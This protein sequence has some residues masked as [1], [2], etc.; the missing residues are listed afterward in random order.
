[1][2]SGQLDGSSWMV[3]NCSK[4]YGA[5]LLDHA[6][7]AVAAWLIRVRFVG[8]SRLDCS[9]LLLVFLASGSQA[10]RVW[11]AVGSLVARGCNGWW[12]VRIWFM[13]GLRL[14]LGWLIRFLLLAGWLLLRR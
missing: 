14:S 5:S 9:L 7:F 13:G 6:W 4:F 10:A 1:V 12:L 2:F 3:R 11:S 8:G